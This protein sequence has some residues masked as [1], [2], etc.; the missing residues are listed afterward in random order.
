M[1][2]KETGM[3]FEVHPSPMKNAEGP[4]S[5][6]E[7]HS[8]GACFHIHRSEIAPFPPIPIFI[9]ASHS[10]SPSVVGGFFVSV[11]GFLM[12]SSIVRYFLVSLSIVGYF[13][14]FLRVKCPVLRCHLGHF[15]IIR[16]SGLHNRI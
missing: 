15:R 6:A 4:S 12:S 5:P 10:D 13:F 16:C 2:K 8:H 11:G 14:I 7:A 3:P 1:P 9:I